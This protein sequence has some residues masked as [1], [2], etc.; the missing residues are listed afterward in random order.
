MTA[1]IRSLHLQGLEA[2]P[3]DI[4]VDVSPGLPCFIIVGLPDT[5]VSEARD[6]V[7][8]AIKN[9]GYA[10]PR[11]RVTVNLAPAHTKKI[12]SHFDLP[13][14]VGILVASG[15]IEQIVED[16]LFGE[17][18]LDGRLHAIR[19]AL[20]LAHAA[21]HKL[22]STI[23]V[24][25]GNR[26]ELSLIG[27]PEVLAARSLKEVVDHLQGKGRLVPCTQVSPSDPIAESSPSVL[28][29]HNEIDFVDIVGQE[30]AKRALTIVAAGGHNMLMIGVPGVGKSMLA[31]A[32][33]SILPEMTPEEQ[34]EVSMIHS[35]VASNKESVVHARPF[36]APHHSASSVSILGGGMHLQPGHLSLAH[37]GVL[38]LDELPEF[39]RD[40]IE[41][42]R[43]PMEDGTVTLSRAHGTV[44][45]PA[46]CQMIAAA[47]PCPCG[48]YGV[49]AQLTIP[50]HCRCSLQ[51]IQQYQ[52]KLS[53]PLLDRM[54]LKLVLSFLSSQDIDR[55]RQ[56]K[57]HRSSSAEI[58]AQVSIA[59]EAQYHRQKK[60]NAELSSKE[61][62]THS[63]LDAPSRELLAAAL[64]Q[65][66]ISLRGYTKTVRVARTIADLQEE[67]RV[68]AGHI[69]EALHYV[70]GFT[71]PYQ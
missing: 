38:F 32:L 19:G 52:R 61:L 27:S 71:L 34:L 10:F 58:R 60:L 64:K 36:R 18:G 69:A 43:Q 13:I 6:R 45:Y 35:L 51:Q 1:T 33:P 11:T 28:F 62:E 8:S 55:L 29:S 57:H 68:T 37:R 17:L 47:N 21:V 16:Y 63:I 25:E 40:V 54:D 24:P 15:A 49:S 31:R 7:R 5:A 65:H 56:A 3:V 39:R 23:I 2:T 53:G 14:A 30:S 12:G 70:G 4:E 41:A 59:R 66:H 9:S 44:Q 26:A 46:R 67:E 48:Y 42:L 22:Y 20:P 50:H